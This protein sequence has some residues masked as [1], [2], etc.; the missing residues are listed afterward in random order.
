MTDPAP[1]DTPVPAPPAAAPPAP[2][3]AALQPSAATHCANCGVALEGNYCHACG[4]PIKG[5]IRPLS[6]LTADVV[7]SVF[8]LDSR[9]LRTLGP[10]Y[11]KPGFLTTEYFIGRRQRYVTP[12]RLF[13]FLTVV[14]FFLAQIYL[15][16]LDFGTS[17]LVDVDKPLVQFEGMGIE[18]AKTVED[19]VRQRDEV[20]KG[21]TEALAE[22]DL[23]VFVRNNLEAQVK[24]VNR[25]AERRLA[26]LKG[27]PAASD[28]A[29]KKPA[30]NASPANAAV[31]AAPGET[32]A[33]PALP[34]A[35]D[36]PVTPRPP[37]T[38]LVTEPEINFMQFNDKAWNAKTNP[39][40]ID[41]LPDIANAK[42]NE[43]IGNGEV[44]FKR[45]LK[46]PKR[47]I[48]LIGVLP[49]S[50]FLIMPLFAV[51]L[52]IFYIF[53]RRYYME[54]LMVALHSHAFISLSILLFCLVSLVEL[55]WPATT[56]VL[57]W[58]NAAIGAWIPL[59]LLIMQKRVYRQ[60]WFMTVLKW[61]IIGF[62][63]IMLISTAVAI[64]AVVGLMLQ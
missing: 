46:E 3:P 36:K 61:G 41:W 29:E 11:F 64:A 44:N 5:M 30:D 21:F 40:R 48:A 17:P 38:P 2:P 28:S 13:F 59:Y 19:V 18:R 31:P 16:R 50:L 35:S 20:V 42:I 57:F 45:A 58:V 39:L 51:L 37:G 14:G 63:Y 22:P 60:N 26:E 32:P 49:Q 54:H 56:P 33:Q 24:R 62:C 1:Y 25:A 7:D 34:A 10:L 23:P 15:G 53:K 4:Q 27:A 55:A 6:G 8:N 47:F 52:K 12:F 9:L 43:M